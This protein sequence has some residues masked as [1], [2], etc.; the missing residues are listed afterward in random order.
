MSRV[1]DAGFLAFLFKVSTET[2]LRFIYY[3]K[4]LYKLERDSKVNKRL[5]LT[6]IRF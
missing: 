5:P 2:L 6:F 3:F 4:Y 1:E